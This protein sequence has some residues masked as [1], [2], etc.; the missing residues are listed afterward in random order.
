M[1]TNKSLNFL[2]NQSTPP[3]TAEE[4]LDEDNFFIGTIFDILNEVKNKNQ[5]INAIARRQTPLNTNGTNICWRI[6]SVAL[7][8]VIPENQIE[9]RQIKPRITKS[10]TTLS[11]YNRI[12]I[13]VKG[14]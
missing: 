8:N 2:D 6:D 12:P 9:T 3:E 10:L 1:S 14:Q 7:V 11:V 4:V 13:P 5:Q